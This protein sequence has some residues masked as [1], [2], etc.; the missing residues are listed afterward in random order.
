MNPIISK[1]ITQLITNPVL[2]NI[3]FNLHEV[4]RN[5]TFSKATVHYFHQPDDPYSQV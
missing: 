2:Q 4:K 3:R 1:I 5:L